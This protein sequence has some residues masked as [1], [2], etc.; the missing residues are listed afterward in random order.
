MNKQIFCFGCTNCGANRACGKPANGISQ[1]FIR[2]NSLEDADQASAS[3][4]SRQCVRANGPQLLG[5]GCEHGEPRP[6]RRRSSFSRTQ[7]NAV[8]CVGTH[9][10]DC[11]C[12]ARSE[13]TN[14]HQFAETSK[15]ACQ[16]PRG[17]ARKAMRREAAKTMRQ[18]MAAHAAQSTPAGKNG[19]GLTRAN[20]VVLRVPV[21]ASI[22]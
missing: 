20:R 21:R 16:S 7:A 3:R 22:L 12:D 14:P 17:L 9:K 6:N 13:A 2:R 10:G 4:Q 11:S 1:I 19:C 15:N 5:D 18:M 8:G